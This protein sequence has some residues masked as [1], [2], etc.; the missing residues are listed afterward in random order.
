MNIFAAQDQP[1]RSSFARANRKTVA[2]VIF[3]VHEPG[4]RL[5][6]AP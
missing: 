5:L 3:F 2:M 6:E 4:N 1:V